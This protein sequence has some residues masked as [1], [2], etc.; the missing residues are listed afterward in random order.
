MII[1]NNE[2][3]QYPECEKMAAVK[4]QSQIISEFLE[5]MQHEQKLIICVYSDYSRKYIP[6]DTT[7]EKLL[8]KFFEIDLDKIEEEQRYMLDEIRNHHQ[9]EK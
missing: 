4:D 6:V 8:A 1:P 3:K 5:W 7:F 9:K 2:E